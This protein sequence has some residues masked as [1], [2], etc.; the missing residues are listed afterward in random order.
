MDG[1]ETPYVYEIRPCKNGCGF[2]LT[3][4]VLLS[5]AIFYMRIQQAVGFAKFY[6]RLHSALIRV[7]DNT[8]KLIEVH[9]HKGDLEEP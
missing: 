8:G 9:R 6:S 2:Q 3:S 5:G 4:D 1:H 7:Y